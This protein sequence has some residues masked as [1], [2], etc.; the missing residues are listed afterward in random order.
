MKIHS[1]SLLYSK[2]ANRGAIIG[3]SIN[4]HWKN[5]N[6]KPTHL[7]VST[8]GIED[9]LNIQYS[10]IDDAG[11]KHFLPIYENP[12]LRNFYKTIKDK[13]KYCLKLTREMA[14]EYPVPLP[15]LAKQSEQQKR[16]QVDDDVDELH[17]QQIALLNEITAASRLT[18]HHYKQRRDEI[19]RSITE[20]QQKN[21]DPFPAG[22]FLIESLDG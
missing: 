5:F 6:E 4:Y 10:Y 19:Q 7:C 17:R 9:E 22:E 21:L 15:A 12:F 2:V 16:F 20:F 8:F 14:E 3:Q 13:E 11:V 1:L 18:Y